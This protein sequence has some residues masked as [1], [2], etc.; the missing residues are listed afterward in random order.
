VA[1]W[2]AL[3]RLEII[4]RP[5]RLAFLDAFIAFV[6]GHEDV[7]ITTTAEIAGRV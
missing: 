2:S 3:C 1:R 6:T 7:W 4:G 5:S